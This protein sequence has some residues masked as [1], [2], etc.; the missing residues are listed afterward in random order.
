MWTAIG[1]HCHSH[2]KCVLSRRAQQNSY[3]NPARF[4][5]QAAD[6][7]TDVEP[8]VLA[9]VRLIH[10]NNTAWFSIVGKKK[11]SLYILVLRKAQLALPLEGEQLWELI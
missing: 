5:K 10:F 3:F 7:G 9:I 8:V 2:P 11:K 4:L 6:G 1:C